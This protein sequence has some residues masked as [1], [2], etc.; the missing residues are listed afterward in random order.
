[1]GVSHQKHN[2]LFPQLLTSPAV[3]DWCRPRMLKVTVRNLYKKVLI[4][5]GHKA[6]APPTDFKEFLNIQLVS[7]K[8]GKILGH[9]MGASNCSA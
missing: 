8:L 2:V 1:M 9:L 7:K 4:F 3:K 6:F 5:Q